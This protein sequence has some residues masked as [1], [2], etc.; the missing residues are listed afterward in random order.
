MAVKLKDVYKKAM[1]KVLL[2][3]GVV[4]LSMACNDDKKYSNDEADTRDHNMEKKT[5]VGDR[6]IV[7]DSTSTT[8]NN[9]YNTDSA[10][11]QGNRF[12]TSNKGK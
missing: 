6:G 3:L 4:M 7:M 1:K 11:G 12:D 2:Y 9:A 8:N 5:E 10:S